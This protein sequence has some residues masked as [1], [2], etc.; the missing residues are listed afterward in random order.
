MTLLLYLKS[1]P[2]RRLGDDRKRRRSMRYRPIDPEGIEED[3]KLKKKQEQELFL[4]LDIIDE[5]D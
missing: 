3:K 1:A 4:L 2:Q 5:D